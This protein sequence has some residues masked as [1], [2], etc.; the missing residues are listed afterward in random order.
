MKDQDT[1]AQFIA[2]RVQGWT[3]DRI[4]QALKVSKPVLID[5]SRQHQF[6]IQNLRAVE[7][8]A[9]ADKHL[10][11]RQQRWQQ[12]GGSLSRVEAEL[13]KRDLADV[14][15]AR[16]ITLASSLRAEAQRETGSLRFT[17]ALND[18]PSGQFV[19]DVM[20]WQV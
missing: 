9:L 20:D 19:E 8:E 7:L 2:L 14:P 13:A 11:S 12:L 5:W 6:H 15:T 3:F 16:L 4:S 18:I 10:A 1:I 17:A